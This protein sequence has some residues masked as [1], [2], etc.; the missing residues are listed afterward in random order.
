M[1]DMTVATP[2]TRRPLTWIIAGLAA[3]LLA[4][5]ITYAVWPDTFTLRGSL[6]VGHS[7]AASTDGS[8][9]GDGGYDDLY[10]GVQVVVTDGGGDTLALGAPRGGKGRRKLVS[11]H[12]R[13]RRHPG[14][15][16]VLRRRDLT[17]RPTPVHG[18]EDARWTLPMDR[19]RPARSDPNGDVPPA[20]SG[21]DHTRSRGPRPVAAL[22]SPPP[23]FHDPRPCTSSW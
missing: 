18:G 20:S 5:A 8:C 15:Q 17:S 16:E 21:R 7:F 12:L 6:R 11:L 13:G 22:R 9:S 10:E 14:R 1:T 23:C 2:W 19:L 3:V 4:S